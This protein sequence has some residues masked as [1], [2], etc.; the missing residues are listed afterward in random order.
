MAIA[1]RVTL[2]T[3]SDSR[4]ASIPISAWH[5]GGKLL[6]IY[7]DMKLTLDEVR[8]GVIGCG[9]VTEKKS[10]PAFN[11]V[12]Q[13]QLVAVMRRDAGKA[14]DYAVRHGV[15]KWYADA[16]VLIDDAEVNAIYVATPPSTHAEYAIKAL[17]ADKPVYVE[18]PMACNY[19]ECLV[20]NHAASAAG[21]PLFVAYYRRSLPYFLQVKAL[22]EAATVGTILAVNIRLTQSP[23]AAD[24]NT[25]NLPWRV[26]PEIA[27]GGYF[28]DL[29]CHTLDIL[30]FI[31]GPISN[32][33]GCCEN[34]GGLYDAEDTVAASFQFENGV[35][36]SG[37]WS[38][39]AAESSRAD[40]VEIIGTKGSIRFSTFAFTPIVVDDG[41][42]LNEY[43]PPNPENIQLHLIAAIVAELRGLGRSPSNGETAAR[44]SWVMDRLVG[45][46]N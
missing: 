32:A 15:P 31:L 34:R 24:F 3:P 20:M 29:A 1:C 46:R 7:S 22:V 38:F 11:K 27:G 12:E 13:S 2:N 26:R 10:A 17:R 5:V 39:V 37:F 16:D 19:A 44:T 36:G 8:W 42:T 23:R 6:S 33:Q 30:D 25:D 40:T 28:F 9:A 21:L 43:L 4:H 41:R 35:I 18:K 14:Q 45:N